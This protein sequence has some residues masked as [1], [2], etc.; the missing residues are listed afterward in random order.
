[1]GRRE[2]WVRFRIFNPAGRRGFCAATQTS[3]LEQTGNPMSVSQGE[4]LA[5]ATPAAASLACPACGHPTRHRLR[6]SVNG[7]DIFQCA[8]CGLGRTATR[9]FDPA[10]YYTGDY[11]SGGHADGYSDYLGSEPV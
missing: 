5:L 11:F 10:A 1:G 2:P 8:A 3:R 9:G 4:E 7:C 6:F